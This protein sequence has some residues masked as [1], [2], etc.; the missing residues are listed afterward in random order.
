MSKDIDYSQPVVREPYLH[1]D[2]S[3]IEKN[4]ELVFKLLYRDGTTKNISIDLE[5]LKSFEFA[6]LREKT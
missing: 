6:L 4:K 5:N 1:F 2:K 3:D